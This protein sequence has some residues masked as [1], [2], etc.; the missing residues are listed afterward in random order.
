MARETADRRAPGAARGPGPSTPSTPAP[1]GA[2]PCGVAA[3]GAQD[4][5]GGEILKTPRR[6]IRRFPG[7]IGDERV[8]FT[9]S[10]FDAPLVC[11]DR[12]ADRAG[13]FG[14]TGAEQH[15]HLGRAV[16]AGLRREEGGRC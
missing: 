11:D 1:P 9:A 4:H 8:N 16:A 2:G 10:R 14:D 15:A 3:P 5:P 6:G 12:P 13:A 7:R